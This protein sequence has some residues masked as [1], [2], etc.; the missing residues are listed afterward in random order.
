MQIPTPLDGAEADAIRRQWESQ[1][2]ELLDRVMILELHN[3]NLER[4]RDQLEAEIERLK[5]KKC[6]HDAARE[7]S[8]NTTSDY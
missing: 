2:Q 6:P 8:K 5:N 3:E 4:I 7:W 1:R